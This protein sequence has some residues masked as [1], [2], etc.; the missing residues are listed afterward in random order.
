[1]NFSDRIYLAVHLGLALLVWGRHDYV[2]HWGGYLAWN[3]IC[4]A[5][6]L[7][8]VRKQRDGEA[9]EFL[10]DWLP[11][12]FFVTVFEQVSHLSLSL[13][14]NWQNG[15]LINF[16]SKIFGVS[17]M[18]WLHNHASNW[19]IEFL[20]FG[21]SAFYLLY[22]LVG[23]LFWMWR[24]RASYGGAFRHLTDALS[25]GY[26]ICFAVYLLFP[27]QSPANRVGVQQIGSS[28]GG[29]FQ[30]VVRAIQ[31]NAGVHGNA[32]PSAHI[33]LSFV[34]LMF[35]Y[36]YLPRLAPWLLFPVLLMCVGAVYDGYHY[37]SDVIA[38]A[39][40]GIA[41]GLAGAFLLENN[42]GAKK[43]LPVAERVE[44]PKA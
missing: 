8:L 18:E 25:A 4:I 23:G 10:H 43:T 21:Y 22:P 41:L 35:A 28:H 17:P 5:L 20:E 15:Y 44:N 11:A 3:L 42:A 1:M 39:A 12:L 16:E 36:R 38:G 37:A 26:A 29:I 19:I 34:V 40:L 33:M 9:W 7:L 13:R 6:I 32:F 27:I 14:G 24:E 30:H 2:P 31:N